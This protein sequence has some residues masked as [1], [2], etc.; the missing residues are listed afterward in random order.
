MISTR[1]HLI[2]AGLGGIFG[3]TV[4]LSF[5]EN[6]KEQTFDSWRNGFERRISRR[7]EAAKVIGASVAIVSKD[8][9]VPYVDAFGFAD[10]AA[11]RKL[12]TYTPMH[13]ASVSKLFTAAA[14]VK[15]FDREGLN[16]HD[17]INDFIDSTVKNPH[18]PQLPITPFHLLTHTSSISDQG[19]EDISSEGDPTLSIADFLT[20]YLVDGGTLY[21]PEKS[22]HKAKPG[23]KWDYSNVAIALAGHVV[24]CVSKKN[25]SAYTEEALFRPLGLRNAHWYLKEFSPDILAKPYEHIYGKYVELPQEGYPDVPAG[26]LRCSVDGLARF[27]AAMLGSSPKFPGF[28]SAQLTSE[29][30]KRQISQNLVGYQGLGWIEEEINGKQFIGHSG[31]DTGASNMVVVTPDHE[32]AV[33]VLMNIEPTDETNRFRAATIEDLLVGAGLAGD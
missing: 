22:F 15:V 27:T 1:R 10:L 16:L 13:L 6:R 11:K 18:Y 33:I 4:K 19:Y 28:L 24:E 32:H 2:K 8:S 20:S 30:L 26:M 29:M 17:D 14:L 21:E 3:S 12:N 25:F 9:G 7:M 31:R 23:T 5:A